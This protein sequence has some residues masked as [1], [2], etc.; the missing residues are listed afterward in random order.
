[1]RLG[2]GGLSRTHPLHE[3]AHRSWQFVLQL[4]RTSEAIGQETK[5]K[6][7]IA[8]PVRTHDQLL[9]AYAC[10]AGCKG[11]DAVFNPLAP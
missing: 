9:W 11:R 3:I 2:S 10:D 4:E 5:A 6:F 1:M 8:F 7:E